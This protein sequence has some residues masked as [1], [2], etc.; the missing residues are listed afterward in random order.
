MY[1]FARILRGIRPCLFIILLKV[2]NNAM[3][4]EIF[5]SALFCLG[6]QSHFLDD[7]RE[8]TKDDITIIN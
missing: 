1:V 3:T 8:T 6:L 5:Q 4:F 2:S 7:I